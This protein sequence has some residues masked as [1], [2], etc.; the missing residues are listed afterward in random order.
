MKI[1]IL[2]CSYLQKR[3]GNAFKAQNLMKRNVKT[4]ELT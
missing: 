2:T 3:V 1:L 4:M